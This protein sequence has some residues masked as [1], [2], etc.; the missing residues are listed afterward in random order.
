MAA[1]PAGPITGR[2]LVNDSLA[3]REPRF[4]H[5]AVFYR[6]PDEY[7]REVAGFAHAG[8][9]R[10]EAVFIAV[11][12]PRTGL[13]RNHLDR[14]AR[15]V[16]VT[17]MT[18]MGAN[19]AWII[20]AVRAFADAHPGRPV[21]YVGEPIWVTRSAAE[22]TEAIRHEALINLAFR[23]SPV[24]ILCPYDATRLD[25]AILTAAGHTHPQIIDNGRPAPSPGYTGTAKLPVECDQ[26]LDAPPVDAAAL[27]YRAR[28]ASVRDFVSRHARQAGL[29]AARVQD[30]ILA[31]HELTA[32][33]LNHTDS[34]G[35]VHFWTAPGEVICQVSDT[36]HIRDPLAGRRHPPPDALHGQGLWVVN[37]L[38]DLVEL[39]TGPGGTTTR[40]HMRR[41]R[42][43]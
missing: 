1:G 5:T 42:R 23:D 9:D 3:A 8:A 41:T 24:S 43:S 19:P 31:V 10:G 7:V 39:R 40:L 20:P 32:N 34:D 12:E 18:R 15:Q 4:R 36:G 26:P 37:R 6:D 35:T 29:P 28:L 14:L 13:L 33:T 30:L 11:P 22:L 25:E 27:A 16:T 21:R 2:P 17:D 38:C